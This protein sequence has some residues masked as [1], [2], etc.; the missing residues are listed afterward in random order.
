MA[1]YYN[2]MIIMIIIMLQHTQTSMNVL[3]VPVVALNHVQMLLETTPVPVD[4]AI[5]WLVMN[6]H[7]MV[8]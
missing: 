3:K 6:T 2:I 5:Y 8:S 7:V 4:L 1:I